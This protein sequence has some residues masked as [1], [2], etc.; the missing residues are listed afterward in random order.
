M[1]ATTLDKF[2]WRK[3]RLTR[4]EALRMLLVGTAWGI[5]T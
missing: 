4:N 1:I 5:T 3:L 2:E